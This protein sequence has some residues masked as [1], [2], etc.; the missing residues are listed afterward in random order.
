[1]INLFRE[2]SRSQPKVSIIIPVFNGDVFLRQAI[3]SALAQTYTNIEIIVVNDGSDDAGATDAIAKSYGDQIRYFSKP[4]GGCG[5]ALNFGIQKMHGELFSWLSHDDLYRPKKIERQV[6][7]YLAQNNPDSIIFSGFIMQDELNRRI[8]SRLAHRY[9]N[10]TQLAKPLYPLLRGLIHGCTLLIPRH[11]FE[12]I[13]Y[14]DERLRTT[15]DYALFFN[16][17]RKVP[18]IYDDH[19]NVIARIHSGQ[20]T[21]KMNAIHL[22]E[23][24]ALWAGF[25]R[26]LNPQEM[27]DL[28]GSE[29]QFL[30]NLRNYLNSTPFAK[31]GS[32]IEH[33]IE[34]CRLKSGNLDSKDNLAIEGSGS[35]KPVRSP[36]ILG[37]EKRHNF[38]DYEGLL[39]KKIKPFV[40]SLVWTA[41][42]FLYRMIRNSVSTIL[43]TFGIFSAISFIQKHY[44]N[45]KMRYDLYR[46]ENH[47]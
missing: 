3:D 33:M 26:Q 2:I 16:L 20:D 27:I 1:M 36:E 42:T 6:T 4:N 22:Q 8:G 12:Q 38:S 13:A 40:P 37:V 46:E 18:L 28:D 5:S 23:G 45:L 17:F 41:T 21:Q 7:K 11:L 32:T 30:F 10:A 14:F 15:Q 31:A 39:V 25:A 29:L 9:L 43:H 34:E 19:V 47:S 44:R 35:L 24:N